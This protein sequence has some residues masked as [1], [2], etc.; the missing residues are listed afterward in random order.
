MVQWQR[1]WLLIERFVV[2]MIR[3]LRFMTTE[4]FSLYEG[5]D[6]FWGFL[7]SIFKARD[8]PTDR[9]VSSNYTFLMGSTTA[10]KTV[11]EAVGTSNDGRILLCSN[12]S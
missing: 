11:T 6:W 10:G 4:A 9:A 1:L 7:S 5:G 3:V 8:K 12:I 2:A